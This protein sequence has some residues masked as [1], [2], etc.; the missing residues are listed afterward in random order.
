MEPVSECPVC[1]DSRMTAVRRTTLVGANRPEDATVLGYRCANGHLCMTASETDSHTP[2]QPIVT[3]E[4]HPS[5]ILD[6][7]VACHVERAK[8][9]LKQ[10]VQ[11]V[12]SSRLLVERGRQ[13]TWSIRRSRPPTRDRAA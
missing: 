10:A 4:P 2:G 5:S 11:A 1:G 3:T 13:L 12:R 9:L 8:W 6:N 7:Q